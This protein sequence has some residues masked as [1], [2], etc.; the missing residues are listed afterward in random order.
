MSEKP[1][2]SL[3]IIRPKQLSNLL[4]VSI[5][6]LYRMESDLPP[7]IKISQNGR[8]VGWRKSTIEKWMDEKEAEGL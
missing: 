8:A 6:T 3:Q 4:G 2:N 1:N 7:K 5:A